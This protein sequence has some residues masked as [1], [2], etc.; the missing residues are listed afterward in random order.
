MRHPGIRGAPGMPSTTQWIPSEP[1]E[2]AAGAQ[3]LPRSSWV[4]MANASEMPICGKHNY[5]QILRSCASDTD[6]CQSTLTVL[7][8]LGLQRPHYP[9]FL[10]GNRGK[11]GHQGQALI[12]VPQRKRKLRM[13]QFSV[14]EL[15]SG[16]M[17]HSVPSEATFLL[18]GL[19]AGRRPLSL[20]SNQIS[21]RMAPAP[22]SF[23]G[24][25]L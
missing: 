8:T 25:F 24:T 17:L 11:T 21:H 9:L 20:W 2:A 3:G 18:A 14:G 10:L 1:R 4:A 23:T 19:E 6:V 12:P 22:W 7:C 15:T 13:G 16:L 5:S